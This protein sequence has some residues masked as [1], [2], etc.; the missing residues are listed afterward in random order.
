[1][2][3]EPETA[4]ARALNTKGTKVTKVKYFSLVYFVFNS[5]LCRT[6]IVGVT[7]RLLDPAI[8]VMPESAPTGAGSTAGD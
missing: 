4:K 8:F 1:M 5:V 3:W 2:D 6:V 7:M